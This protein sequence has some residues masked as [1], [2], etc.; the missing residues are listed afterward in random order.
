MAICRLD[1][2]FGLLFVEFVFL[3]LGVEF[4]GC[5]GL[6]ADFREFGVQ[7]GLGSAQLGLRGFQGIQ[8]KPIG[9]QTLADDAFP[10]PDCEVGLIC[11]RFS[12]FLLGE[13]LDHRLDVVAGIPPSTDLQHFFQRFQNAGGRTAAHFPVGGF[14][15]EVEPREQILRDSIVDFHLIVA[16]VSLELFVWAVGLSPQEL[17][18]LGHPLVFGRPTGGYLPT[19]GERLVIGELQ[20]GLDPSLDLGARLSLVPDHV[21]DEFPRSLR[22]FAAKRAIKQEINGAEDGGLTCVVGSQDHHEGGFLGIGKLDGVRAA[23]TLEIVKSQSL[24]NHD[25]GRLLD[26][27]EDFGFQLLLL[28][29]LGEFRVGLQVQG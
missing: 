24:E 1:R 10:V 29:L 23:V 16:V 17:R 18:R 22:T 7:A 14:S 12:G 2:L 26:S 20:P 28:G 19:D 9:V 21:S 4:L 15:L 5:F 13:R 6:S 3:E 27:P 25:R 11:S 8:L